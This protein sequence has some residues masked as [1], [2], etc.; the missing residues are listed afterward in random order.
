[1]GWSVTNEF[2]LLILKVYIFENDPS[3]IH[4]N[5]TISA[6]KQELGQRAASLGANLVREAIAEKGEANIIVATGASQFEML[7]ALIE[8]EI[9]WSKVNGFHLDE[10]IDLPIDHPASF[11]KYLKERFVDKVKPQNFYYVDGEKDPDEECTRL[12]DIMGKHPIDVA[13]VGIGENAHLAFND[14]PADFQTKVS[15]LAV[16]LDD[17]CRAQQFNEGWFNSLAEVPKRAI[18]MSIHQILQS[19]HIICSVPDQR[20]S[21]AVSKALYGAVSPEIPASVLQNH[22]NTYFYLDQES[23]S[24]IPQS[25]NDE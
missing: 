24:R 9:D 22:Q 21:D 14:P 2:C 18:S 5:I 3:T 1:M 7:S 17:A 10:Y 11:R 19:K 6:S 15:F 13:F 20:K 16:N 25:S 12:A 8:E 23:A 4:M